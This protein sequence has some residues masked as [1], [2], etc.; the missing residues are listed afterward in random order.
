MAAS[1]A[2]A[3]Q[4]T[5]QTLILNALDTDQRISPLSVGSWALYD[6]ANTIFSLNIISVYFPQFVV[7]DRGLN[8]AVYAYPM[9]AAL[10]IVA[11]IMPALGAFSDRN[12]GRRMPWLIATTLLT[13][14]MTALMGLTGELTLI[15]LALVIANIG[16][17]TALIFYDALLPSVSTTLNWGKVSGLGVGLG[18]AGALLGGA[19]V[20]ALITK[21][22]GH[23]AAQDAFLPTAVLFLV[24]ALPCFFLVRERKNARIEDPTAPRPTLQ[25]SLTQT[26]RTLREARQV[27]GLFTFLVANFFYS[28]ALNT[29]IIAMGVYAVQVIG[30][31]S[32][33]S[34]LAPAIITAVIGS[35]LF[36]LVTDWLTSK[37]ALIIALVMWV[38]VFL[39]AMF[40]TD[41]IIFQWVIAPVAGIALG[42]TWTAARTMMIELSPPE[43]LGEFLGLY[44]LT[45]KFSAVLGPLLWGTTLLLLDPRRYGQF[46]YQIAIG[47]L[48]VMVLVGLGLHLRTPNIR[49]VGKA[50]R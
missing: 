17:Q 2:A 19:I 16:Y 12:G 31:S 1:P 38:G 30:F 7:Q 15:I 5:S 36:G 29:V 9:S 49:R 25:G 8:D 40:T 33:F 4:A 28:D 50:R 37:Q 47:T 22:D 6:F 14:V 42:S 44:N 23:V 41:K 10:L 46:A 3:P 20:S 34:V 24:F 21:P 27:P 32:A 35:L 39:A 45:G 48:L 26:V 13:V 11:L 18:Y 43:R